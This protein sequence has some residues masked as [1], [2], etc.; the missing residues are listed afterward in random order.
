MRTIEAMSFN[1]INRLHLHSSDSQSWSLEIPSL[2][3]LTIKG[4]YHP[5][6]IWKTQDLQEVQKY[7]RIRGVEVHIE[8][9]LPGHTAQSSDAGRSI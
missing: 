9:D 4:A 3:E 7:G 5:T 8:I 6:Q 1:K 2:H